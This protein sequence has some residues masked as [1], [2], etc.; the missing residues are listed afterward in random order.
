MLG[1]AAG[2]APGHAR[3]LSWSLRGWPGH[4]AGGDAIVRETPWL[5]SSPLTPF[6]WH[7]QTLSMYTGVL[8]RCTVR[9][10]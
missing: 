6:L 10:L 7:F 4:A 5:L 3:G 8:D 9:H 2:V 1:V